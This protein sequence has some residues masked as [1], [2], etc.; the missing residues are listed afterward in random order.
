M[1]GAVL[2]LTI[3]FRVEL[4]EPPTVRVT[5]GGL[6]L[7][8]G[9]VG[10]TVAASPTTPENPLTLESVTVEEELRLDGAR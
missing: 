3:T 9:P 8:V 5:L 7:P 6:R 10:E 4:P 2:T 1:A